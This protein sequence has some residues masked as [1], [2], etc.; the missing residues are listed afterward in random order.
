MI[1]ELLRKRY[2]NNKHFSELALHHGGKKLAHGIKHLL[3]HHSMYTKA[4][5]NSLLRTDIASNVKLALI[6]IALPDF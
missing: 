4:A 1:I 6:L 5:C 2:H 3:Q